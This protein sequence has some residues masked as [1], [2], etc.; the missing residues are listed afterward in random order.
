MTLQLS[1]LLLTFLMLGHLRPMLRNLSCLRLTKTSFS[2]PGAATWWPHHHLSGLILSVISSERALKLCTSIISCAL[3]SSTYC[4][5]QL[6]F[7]F[8]FVTIYCVP[9]L[10]DSQ[11]PR[12]KDGS[13][14]SVLHIYH[15]EQN[16]CTL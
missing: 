14:C 6:Q 9:C 15:K 10:L 13:I 12:G 2:F 5:L 4:G 8:M 11:F 7:M 3:L 1:P 16:M